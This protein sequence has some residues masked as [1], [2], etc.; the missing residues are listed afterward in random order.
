MKRLLNSEMISLGFLIAPVLWIGVLGWQASY[1]PTDS[2]KRQCEET[3][4]TS[5]QKTEECKRAAQRVANFDSYI[6]G[7]FQCRRCWIAD[8][9]RLRIVTV[10]S[11][12]LRELNTYHCFA[13]SY[14]ITG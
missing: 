10:P 2:E 14:E 4:H 12:A 6:D 1:V 11:K 8:A 13:C 3:A 5:G 9:R 7:V